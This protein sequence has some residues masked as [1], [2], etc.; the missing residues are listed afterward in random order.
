MDLIQICRKKGR[1]WGRERETNCNLI[2]LSWLVETE[3]LKAQPKSWRVSFVLLVPF[4]P[5][6]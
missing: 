6:I 3:E 5:E 2:F 1:L 4:K